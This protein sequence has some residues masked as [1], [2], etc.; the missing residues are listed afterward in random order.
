MQILR[1]SKECKV[2]SSQCRR[3]EKLQVGCS[4]WARH[5]MTYSACIQQHIEVILQFI[6]TKDLPAGI[7]H[8]LNL[9]QVFFQSVPPA[10]PL[11]KLDVVCLAAILGG[12]HRRRRSAEIWLQTSPRRVRA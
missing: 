8:S 6:G 12:R 4:S 2:P 5:D 11:V 1:W 10:V 9:K 7:P 3:L